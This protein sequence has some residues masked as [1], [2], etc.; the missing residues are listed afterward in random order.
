MSRGHIDV[1][2]V[3]P[4]RL[5]LT[6]GENKMKPQAYKGGDVI[7]C[8]AFQK[9]LA[10]GSRPTSFAGM[11][12]VMLIGHVPKNGRDLTKVQIMQNLGTLGLITIDDVSEFAGEAIAEL[13]IKKF[14]EKWFPKPKEEKQLILTEE[15]K[16]ESIIES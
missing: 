9:S 8:K 16:N 3:V 5:F 15:S 2:G 1:Y 11:A 14:E 10:G 12:A 4:S 13:C 6:K 7:Y